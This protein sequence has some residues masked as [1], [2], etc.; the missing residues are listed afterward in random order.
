LERHAVIDT[1]DDAPR[2][3]AKLR[4]TPINCPLAS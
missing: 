4:R 2:T 3:A 1:F